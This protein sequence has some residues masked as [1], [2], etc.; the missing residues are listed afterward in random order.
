MSYG[1]RMKEKDEKW[2]LFWCNLLHEIIFDEVAEKE[3]NRHLQEICQ[4]EYLF[5]NGKRKTPSL[6]TLRRKLKKYRNGGLAMLARQSRLDR[7]KPRS[8]SSEI[9][10]K[11]VEIKSEQPCRSDDA[12]NRFLNAEYGKT[13][14]RSTLYRHLKLNGATKIKLGVSKQKVRKRWTRDHTHDLWVG[15][16][17]EGPYVFVDGEV[18]PTYLCL[19]IDCYSRYVV[20]GRYYLRQSLPILE[21]SLIRAWMVHGASNDLYVDHAKVYESNALKLACYSIPIK[22]LH[23]A[24]GD[25][26]PGGLIE[27]FFGTAQTQFEAEV[28]AGDILT[29][30]ELNQGFTAY[31]EVAYHPRIHSETGQPPKERYQHGL[32]AIRHVDMDDA[33]NFFVKKDISRVNEDFSDVRIDNRYYRVNKTLRGDKV[34]VKYDPFSDRQNVLIYSLNDEYLCKGELYEREYGDDTDI[35]AKPAKPRHDYIELLKQE[36][37]RQL[38]ERSKGIDYRK[39][40]SQRAWSFTAF[41]QKL[42]KL[43]G[44]KGGLGAFNAREYEMLKKAYNRFPKLNEPMLVKAWEKAVQ[45]TIPYMVYELQQ[46]NT[47]GGK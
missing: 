12:I 30:N 1:D 43:M 47:Q 18:L 7:G 11:A 9:I 26:P 20:E 35:S 22:L 37:A 38:D 23:R 31:L 17:E 40:I 42:S 4:K 29:L 39:I 13:I 45:K 24:K 19:F 14:P 3:I 33:I 34:Q 15:D 41:A 32:K 6:S 27:R 36:H 44:R 28:R 16:F 5:P 46:I 10:D 21:D 25:P 8:V 2:S